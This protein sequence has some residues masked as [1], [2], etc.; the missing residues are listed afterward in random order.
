MSGDISESTIVTVKVDNTGSENLSKTLVCYLV[1]LKLN[2]EQS[3]VQGYDEAS[4]TS[5]R[6]SGLSARINK[7]YNGLVLKHQAGILE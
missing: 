1:C 7:S 3:C 6:L 5:G 2:V 4:N